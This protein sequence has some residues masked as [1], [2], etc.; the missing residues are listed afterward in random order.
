MDRITPISKNRAVIIDLLTRAKKFHCPT[1]T[2]WQF[3]AEALDQAR[4]K[5]LVNERPLSMTA[6]I[7]KATSLF[8]KIHPRFNRHVFSRVFR[9]Y[10]VAFDKI[11]CTM[12]VRRQSKD[13]EQMLLPL[14]LESSDE[15]TVTEIQEIIDHH[16]HCK[17]EELSQFQAFERVKKMPRIAL[18]WFS[19]KSRSDHR[20]YRKY[21]GTY[22]IS[23]M[24]V[25]SFGP[26][27]GHTIAN[28]ATAFVIGP[29]FDVPE[30]E[31]G[32]IVMR[33]KQGITLISDHFIIDGMDILAG[34]KT[35]EGLLGN[36]DKLGLATEN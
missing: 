30:A 3:D 11:C 6:C 12:I 20:F 14:M 5:V 19:Y 18:S 29:L 35:L 27:G 28:T 4:K 24:A 7:I 23:E 8:L 17:L 15:L 10:V 26:R 31:N 13:G 1:T 9:R 34:M 22:G 33:K 21:F 36:P 16:R 25:G 32:Q 2:A